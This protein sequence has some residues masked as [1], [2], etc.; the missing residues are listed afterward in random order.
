MRILILGSGLIP[1]SLDFVTYD[2]I[3]CSNSSIGAVPSALDFKI[4]HLCVEEM[5]FTK[6]QLSC[7][8]TSPHLD[9]ESALH[10]RLMRRR[11]LTGRSPLLCICLGDI[12]KTEMQ[13]IRYNPL[14][15]ERVSKPFL[16]NETIRLTGLKIFIQH[17]LHTRSEIGLSPVRFLTSFLRLIIHR[18][19]NHP[20]I[21]PDFIK[22]STGILSY[23]VASIYFQADCIHVSGIGSD[24]YFFSPHYRL[25][26]TFKLGH[27]IDLSLLSQLSLG[28]NP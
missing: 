12:T 6:E 16:I 28:P 25:D 19:F 11:L 23:T 17:L 18:Y 2:Y 8:P 15:Y 21:L 13:Q 26:R 4:I 20:I 22:P 5:F 9:A 3:F 10:H 27:T 7:L 14:M 1:A 24:S